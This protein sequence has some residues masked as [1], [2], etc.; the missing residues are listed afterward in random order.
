MKP[1]TTRLPFAKRV[2]DILETYTPGLWAKILGRSVWS[3]LD[4]ERENPY[5]MAGRGALKGVLDP[6][7]YRNLDELPEFKGVNTTT[8]FLARHIYDRL[9]E[10]ARGGKL[11][12]ADREL[13]SYELKFGARRANPRHRE[14]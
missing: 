8:E 2:L 13:G 3:P 6:L 11:G 10:A 4:L 1:P 9:A 14:S 5:L 7:N 12:R